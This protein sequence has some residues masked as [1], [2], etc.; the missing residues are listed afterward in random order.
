MFVDSHCHLNYLPNPRAALASARERGIDGVLCIGVEETRIGEVVESETHCTRQIT[1]RA[2]GA[3]QDD[4]PVFRDKAGV[5]KPRRQ[6][7][8]ADQR[9]REGH[10]DAI[11]GHLPFV[12]GNNP[13]TAPGRIAGSDGRSSARG[14]GSSRNACG[15]VTAGSGSPIPRA[16]ATYAINSRTSRQGSAPSS[17]STATSC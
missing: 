9:G 2:F 14:I 12:A 8:V 17:S 6:D 7:V 11:F 5:Q 13:S 16:E 3:D 1:P 4:L 10:L 15:S